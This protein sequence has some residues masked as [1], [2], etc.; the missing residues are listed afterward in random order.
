MRVKVQ[1][2]AGEVRAAFLFL[3]PF[4]IASETGWSF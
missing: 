1:V 2:A 4:R 3:E